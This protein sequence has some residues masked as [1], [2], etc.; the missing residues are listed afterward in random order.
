MR[1]LNTLTFLA[2]VII[3]AMPLKPLLAASING[4]AVSVQ[5]EPL[6]GVLVVAAHSATEFGGVA[7]TDDAGR[8]VIEDLPF[9]AYS[10][11]ATKRGYGTQVLDYELQ[12]DQ[13]V[14]LVL[15]LARI[16]GLQE[17]DGSY[18]QPRNYTTVK[19]FYGT[20]RQ[21][22]SPSDYGPRRGTLA[23][24]SC[25]VTIPRDHKMGE[26]ES[27]SIWR[28]EF[29][30]D[31]EKHVTLLKVTPSSEDEFRSE[32]RSTISASTSKSAFV[33]IHGYNVSFED[34]ARRT[35][36]LAYD[37]GFDGAPIFFSWPSNGRIVDYLGDEDNAAWAVPHLAQFLTLIAQQSGANTV[38]LIAHSMGN[39]VLASS[40]A[41]MADKIAANGAPKFEQIA[42]VAPDIDAQ[43]FRRDIV[44]RLVPT[45]QRVT[46]YA[47]TKDNALL[48]AKKIRAGY[49]RAGD[50][51]DG[52]FVMNGV[53]TIDVSA[54]DT[55]LLGHSYYADNE[56][57]IADLFYLI[58]EGLEPSRRARLRAKMFGAQRYWQF[59]R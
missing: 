29:R 33:F 49:P 20:D 59:V 55:S 47:S 56:T 58:R 12:T 44:P 52:P 39:R 43:I 1:Y 53:D 57:I 41:D 25:E 6:P 38:H 31:P 18:P 34:A 7:R 51:N 54:I 50:L 26:L 23:M 46:L 28:F 37:L 48:L 13:N 16:A 40:L 9:G 30:P 36:Q 21:S 2:F 32:L 5:G 42:L 8:F 11:V 19:V 24:G 15:R 3:G 22:G 10:V 45:G 35:A 27:R 14:P 17:D 4:Q